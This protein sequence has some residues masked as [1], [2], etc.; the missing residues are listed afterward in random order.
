MGL[1]LGGGTFKE[2]EMMLM[3]ELIPPCAAPLVRSFIG[4]RILNSARWD[5]RG[6]GAVAL[7]GAVV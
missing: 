3:A 1:G 2:S 7:M 5:G 4:T 6:G